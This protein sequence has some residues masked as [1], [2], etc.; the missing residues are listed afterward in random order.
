MCR[1]EK[2]AAYGLAS[3]SLA[4]VE[5]FDAG[6]KSAGGE[7]EAIG[8]DGYAQ[9]LVLRPSGEYFQ[10][11][12]L[13]GFSQAVG[14]MLRYWL[15]VPESFLEEIQGLGQACRRDRGDLESAQRSMALEV[16]LAAAST[17]FST[18]L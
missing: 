2:G 11:S 9:Y 1:F 12:G 13:D 8:D 3:G 17:A 14:E 7:V 18:S 15:A 16:I 10:V 4:H 6:E 5:V